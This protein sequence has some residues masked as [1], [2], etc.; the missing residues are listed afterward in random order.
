M[1]RISDLDWAEAIARRLVDEW[2]GSA[3]DPDD[4]DLLFDVL[5]KSLLKPPRQM[6][7]LIGTSL[8]EQDYFDPLD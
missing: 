5:R 6:R 4:A 7:R 8:I 2:Y 3:G 1:N